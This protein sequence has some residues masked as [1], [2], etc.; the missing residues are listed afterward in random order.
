M[1]RTEAGFDATLKG[2]GQLLRTLRDTHTHRA[3]CGRM[4]GEFAGQTVEEI[5]KLWADIGEYTG[6]RAFLAEFG[7]P[8][9]ESVS[10]PA[11]GAANGASANV[12]PPA[13][14]PAT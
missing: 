12:S 6:L 11:N 2:L 3:D 10:P 1:I 7:P 13:A 14:S 8:P 5:L 9:D 4:Y